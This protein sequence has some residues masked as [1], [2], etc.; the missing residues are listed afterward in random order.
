VDAPLSSSDH[1]F[2]DELCT[3]VPP[4]QKHGSNESGLSGAGFEARTRTQVAEAA[5][6]LE[7]LCQL[8]NLGWWESTLRDCCLSWSLRETI[9]LK[10]LDQYAAVVLR[11]EAAYLEEMER[12]TLLTKDEDCDLAL[13]KLKSEYKGILAKLKEDSRVEWNANAS[14]LPLTSINQQNPQPN[15]SN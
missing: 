6:A 2:N 4:L 12:S 1:L 13:N 10:E 15:T 11:K 8:L 14:M 9:T 7:R 3:V 5:A